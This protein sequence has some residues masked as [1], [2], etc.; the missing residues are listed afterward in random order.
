MTREKDGVYDALIVG[1]GITGASLLYV[2]TKYANLARIVLLEKYEKPA[3]INSH[4]DNNSQT[5]HFGD[6]ETNYSFEKAGKVKGAASLLARYLEKNDGV[7]WRPMPKMVLAVGETEIAELEARF[8]QF[9]ELFPNLR[10]LTKEEIGL[11]EPKILEKRSPQEKL[12]ALFTEK[13]YGVNFQKLAE[14]FIENAKEEKPKIE[15]FFNR[16]VKKIER[17]NGIWEISTNEGTLKT[18]VAI[19]AAGPHSLIFAKQAGY[20]KDFGILP[21]AGSFYSAKNALKNKVYTMQ[22]KKLPFAAVH[23]DPDVNEPEETRFGPTAKVLPILER[24]HYSTLFDFLKTS[25][26]NLDGVFSLLKIL[27]DK[28]IS[29]Y[30]L[31]NLAFDIPF[32]GKLLF[33]KEVRK[34]VPSMK[35]GQLSRKKKIGGIRPQIVNTKTKKL[36][37]GEAKIIGENIIFNITPSPGA[38]VCLKSAFDDALTLKQFFGEEYF[39]DEA[40]FKKDL[41]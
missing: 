3:Q 39:F 18:R 2:L 8:I 7:I 15:I 29:K 28:T 36:E 41:S 20:G 27:S 33:L 26:F 32:L 34:I 24:H 5:L 37:M 9:K 14:S 25:A 4:Y 17:R 10:R 11:I 22:I 1:A 12:L 16:N 30:I 23:G 35:Y 13:G 6:I 38:S 31:K 21:V 19:L 40:K